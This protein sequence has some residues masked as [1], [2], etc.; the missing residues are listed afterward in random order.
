MFKVVRTRKDCFKKYGDY[1]EV[2]VPSHSDYDNVCKVAAEIL[3]VEVDDNMKLRLFRSDGTMISDRI[4]VGSHTPWTI[5]K[6]LT[7][8]GRVSRICSNK[9]IQSRGDKKL[10]RQT[11]TQSHSPDDS[12]LRK[13]RRQQ[14]HQV[15]KNR[16]L[17]GKSSSC[18]M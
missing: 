14:Q 15:K 2:C 1:C 11:A 12:S 10:S 8:S 17:T 5:N 13:P 4:V 3:E 7:L 16:V 9:K 6:Y 18:H